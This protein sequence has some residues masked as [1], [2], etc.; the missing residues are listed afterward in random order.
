MAAKYCNWLSEKEGLQPCYEVVGDEDILLRKGYLGLTGYRLPTEAEM[1]YAT[2]AGAK[3]SRFFGETEDLLSKY[4]WHVS[5]SKN[6]SWPV[7]S[8]KPN[9]FGLFDVHGNVFTWCQERTKSYP[10][11]DECTEDT[12]DILPIE[13]TKERVMRGGSFYNPASIVRSAYRTNHVPI[14]RFFNFGFRLAR[15]LSVKLEEP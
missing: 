3:T 12:E 2:R 10:T 8:L 1:Q 4:A 7:G 6:H 11:G 14:F 15:T 5:N 9:D 13:K